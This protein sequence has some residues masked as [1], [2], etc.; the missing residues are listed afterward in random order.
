M[1]QRRIKALVFVIVATPLLILVALL[2]IGMFGG[3]S[4]H[5]TLPTGRRIN[6]YSNAMSLSSTFGF[7]T[8][9]IKTGGK[10]IVVKPT[11][12]IVDGTVVAS[13]NEHVTDIEV[14]VKRG[15]IA[16]V[17]D[18]KLVPTAPR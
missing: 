14:R 18:G 3:G 11:R 7:D 2:A 12:L 6:A 5:G 16:F 1:P 15:G 9:T 10:T 13:I 4:A 17:A 8:A